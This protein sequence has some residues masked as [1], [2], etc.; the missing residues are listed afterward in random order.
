MRFARFD[1]AIGNQRIRVATNSSW[2]DSKPLAKRCRSRWA[3]LENGACHLFP[4]TF[5]IHDFHNGIV[6]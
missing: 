2:R 3:I 6:S 4:G 5:A 1:I